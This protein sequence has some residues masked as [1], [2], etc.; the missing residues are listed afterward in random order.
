MWAQRREPQ[1]E[2]VLIQTSAG[3]H[4]E[5]F[6][7]EKARRGRSSVIMSLVSSCCLSYYD[8]PLHGN[9][10]AEE[11]LEESPW[12]CGKC[13]GRTHG[14]VG[15]P[16]E[17]LVTVLVSRSGGEEFS[18]GFR[19]ACEAIVAQSCDPLLAVVHVNDILPALN[20]FIKE[21][22]WKREAGTAPLPILGSPPKNGAVAIAGSAL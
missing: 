19:S 3:L 16:P 10:S 14:S 12:M 9:R 8:K 15:V 21:R 11:A 5:L 1:S 17:L 6:V 20:G 18:Q 22:G 2:L 13:H 4:M 7:E